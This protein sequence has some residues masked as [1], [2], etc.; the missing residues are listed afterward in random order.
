MHYGANHNNNLVSDKTIEQR[1]KDVIRKPLTDAERAILS[2][3][4]NFFERKGSLT[5]KQYNLLGS[6]QN[7]YCD[8]NIQ[9]TNE[10]ITNFDEEKKARLKLA[11]KYYEQTR[12]F[13][14]LV[15]RIKSEPNYIPTE[16]QYNSMCHNKYFENALKN[17]NAP[18]TFALADLVVFRNNNRTYHRDK[19]IIGL[20]EAIDERPSFEKGGRIYTMMI[21]GTEDSYKVP[22]S[23]IKMYREKK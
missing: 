17:Y 22:E 6:I 11:A 13:S 20:I 14:D 5:T 15:Y 2:S 23:D 19:S 9:K 10:W 8:A 18:P 16:K 1:L 12:Y 4:Q 3:F 21:L 7:R